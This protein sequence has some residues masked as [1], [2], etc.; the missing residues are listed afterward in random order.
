MVAQPDPVA[1][2]LAPVREQVVVLE[3]A[4]HGAVDVGAGHAGAE[5]VERDL[6][7]GDRVV[8][9]APHLVGR[10]ADDHRPLELGVVAPDRR[11]RLGD[12]HVA[13]LELDVVGDGVRPRA[14]Q[15]DLAAVAGRDAVGGRL[16]A[17]VGAVERREQ[18]E[19]RLVPRAQG[20]LGLGRARPRVLLQQPVRVLAPARAL[21]DQR[22]LGLALPHQQALDERRERRDRLA[23]DLAQRRALV[24]EDAGIA[25]L[26]GARP[27]PTRRAR[28]AR[29]RGDASGAR[30]PDTPDTT[31][32]ARTTSPPAPA[33]P[34][35]R[36][37]RRR[38][39]RR[40]C[41]RP[42]PAARSRGS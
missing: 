8:E 23:G 10:R 5:C 17:A 3:V 20:R 21:A 32:P 6:L 26:V 37:R 39:R 25:V 42:P 28:A 36:A 2:V 18:R 14:P 22:H 38:G 1:D 29:R 19:R 12:E 30:A 9:Q 13:L 35:T 11:A 27:G 34:R 31:R 15:P 4:Q 7:R 16:L 40:R 33:R 41:R 24:A